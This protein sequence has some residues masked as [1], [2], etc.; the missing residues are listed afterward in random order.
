[1][2]PWLLVMCD[3][4]QAPTNRQYIELEAKKPLKTTQKG[5]LDFYRLNHNHL[6]S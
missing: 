4:D 3:P 1:M 6:L 2:Q 5:D